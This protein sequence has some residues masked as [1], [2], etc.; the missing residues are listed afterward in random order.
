M[1]GRRRRVWLSDCATTCKDRVSH[2]VRRNGRTRYGREWD[3]PI[4][5]TLLQHYNNAIQIDE[6][7]DLRERWTSSMGVRGVTHASAD[8][9]D[10]SER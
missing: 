6:L 7:L 4:T 2:L 8:A 9:D 5:G 3:L 1:T 10:D